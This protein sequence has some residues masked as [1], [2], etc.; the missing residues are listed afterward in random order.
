MQ[1]ILLTLATFMLAVAPNIHADDIDTDAVPMAYFSMPFGNNA[2][3]IPSY[4]LQLARG[5]HD[6]EGGVNLFS[7]A[8][9]MDLNFRGTE[10]NAFELNGINT[11]EKV[12]TYNVNG[13]PQTTSS[14]NWW[15][16]GIGA[17][18][19]YIL[20]K[21]GDDDDDDDDKCEVDFTNN[22]QSYTERVCK[23]F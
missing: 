17:V 18:G 2:D 12:T 16:V 1:K 9:Y 10:V 13:D 5:Q 6:R 3:S 22:L 11:L 20:L 21:G 19:G 23:V 14:I 7:S 4:G 15:L 8:P